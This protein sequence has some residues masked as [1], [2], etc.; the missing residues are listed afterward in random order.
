MSDDGPRTRN[1]KG[2]GAVRREAVRLTDDLVTLDPPA[3]GRSLPVVLRATVDGVDPAAWAAARRTLIDQLLAKHAALVFRGFHVAGLP[4]FS[5]FVRALSG[6][7]LE[8]RERSSPRTHLSEHIYTST[9]HPAHQT[10]FLHNENSYA[11]VWPS[12]LFFFCSVAPLVGGETPLAD[13]RE[14][15]KSIEP[16]IVRRFRERRVLYV[17]NF[18][19]GVGL[20]WQTVFGTSD[21]STVEASCR[22]AGYTVEWKGANGLRTKRVGPAVARHPRTGELTWFN[23][24][25]FFHVSTLEAELREALLA[26]F[27]PADLPNN[28]YYGDGAPI[29]ASVLDVLRGAYLGAKVAPRWELMDILMVDNMLAAH[30]REPFVG[31]RRINVA[32]CEPCTEQDI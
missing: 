29:E 10:I 21:R 8:Y 24:A 6:D 3:A 20:P 7:L 17:R 5:Q 9:E 4:G 26:Q 1:L 23:H 12:R 25:T 27:D 11:H 19:E 15:L 31:P 14:V 28:T 18:N 13:C 30:G 2:L 32:M 16:T 22:E